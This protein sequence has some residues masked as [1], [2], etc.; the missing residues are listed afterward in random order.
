MDKI[1][2]IGSIFDIARSHISKQAKLDS[3]KRKK[4]AS[5][6][7]KKKP[8]KQSSDELKKSITKKLSA[9]DTNNKNY[10]QQSNNIFLES[11]LIWEFGEDII[12]DSNFQQMIVKLNDAICQNKET[13][14]K[15][16][17]LIQQLTGNQE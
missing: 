2:N 7:A 5:A 15:F 17:L 8:L 9:L 6:T 3:S 16:D 1:K 12:N 11:V 4:P 14:N 13:S 10:K